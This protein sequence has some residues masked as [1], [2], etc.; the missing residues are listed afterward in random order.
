MKAVYFLVAVAMLHSVIIIG[1]ADDDDIIPICI[2]A[3]DKTC[4]SA[5]NAPACRAGCFKPCS[6]VPRWPALYAPAAAPGP[7]PPPRHRLIY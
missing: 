4:T 5:A 6:E 2:T 1:K 3:C 7:S